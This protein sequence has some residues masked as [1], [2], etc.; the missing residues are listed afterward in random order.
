MFRRITSEE[1]KPAVITVEATGNH[2]WYKLESEMSDDWIA[3]EW[4]GPRWSVQNMVG[5]QMF[6]TIED[7]PKRA[8]SFNAPDDVGE[9]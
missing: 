2:K 8:M 1:D 3:Y 9:S 6:E 7:V 5:S 4:L